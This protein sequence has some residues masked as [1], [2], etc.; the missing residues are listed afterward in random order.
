MLL[1]LQILCKIAFDT[2]DLHLLA[3]CILEPDPSKDIELDLSHVISINDVIIV[4]SNQILFESML[5]G[6]PG[7]KI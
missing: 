1:I 5:P 4:S 6:F 7:A 3:F 2:A